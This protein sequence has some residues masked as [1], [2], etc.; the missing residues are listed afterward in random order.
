[1]DAHQKVLFVDAA[2]GYYRVSRFPVGDFFGPVDLGLHLAG[3]YNSLNI[4]V[5]LLAGSIF[6]GSNRLIFTGLLARAGAG[7]SS[8]RWAAPAWSSTTSASTCCRWSAGRRHRPCSY[9]NRTHGEEIDVR[10]VPRGPAARLG[11]AAGVASTP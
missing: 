10:L 3:R 8:R 2:T 5:G 4:G 11:D 7:S 9:L 6:P 1:M